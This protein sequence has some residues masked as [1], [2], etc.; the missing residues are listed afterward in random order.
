MYL[1]RVEQV[2]DQGV[3]DWEQP[4]HNGTHGF[5]GTLSRARLRLSRTNCVVL[6]P[7]LNINDGRMGLVAPV[8]PFTDWSRRV[9]HRRGV[10]LISGGRKIP[11]G[12][13]VC[14]AFPIW[15]VYFPKRWTSTC[16]LPLRV[17]ACNRIRI[18]CIVIRYATAEPMEFKL[19]H[20][21]GG[22]VVWWR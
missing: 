12:S 9:W 20:Y 15:T 7:S 4:P 5:C 17:N 14:V 11:S 16:V 22:Y 10:N 21:F 18:I 19:P 1:E 6:R 2:G 13:R 8:G 3:L